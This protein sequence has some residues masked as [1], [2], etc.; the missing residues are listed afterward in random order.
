MKTT[1]TQCGD[2]PRVEQDR[3]ELVIT[4]SDTGSGKVE[5]RI[6]M[7]QGFAFASDILEII[8]NYGKEHKK[9]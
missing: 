6:N 8:H 5:V 3:T 2:R 7:S 9:K 4:Y 1:L